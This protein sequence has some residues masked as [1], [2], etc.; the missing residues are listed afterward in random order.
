MCLNG[1]SYLLRHF[2]CNKK[3]DIFLMLQLYNVELTARRVHEMYLHAYAYSM[4]G[5]GFMQSAVEGKDQ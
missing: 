4:K 5:P 3:K 2:K 1:L